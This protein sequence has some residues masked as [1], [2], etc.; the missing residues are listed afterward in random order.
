MP[1]LL[2]R[3]APVVRVGSIGEFVVAANH[4]DR[5]GRTTNIIDGMGS[6]YLT[7]DYSTGQMLSET[8]GGGTL[9]GANL[10][11]AYDQFL[12]RT[13]LLLFATNTSLLSHSY[14]FDGTSRI[15]NV[16][17]GTYE[18][19]YTYLANS[20][21]ISQIAYRSNSTTQMTTVKPVSYTHL[22]LPTNREV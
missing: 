22:T 2:R 15:T 6:R 5:L 7:Y 3:A 21:F 10:R 9:M 11:F 16:S 18:A 1:A 13:N 20:P 17:D 19:G 12:R 8:N 14:A 4:F